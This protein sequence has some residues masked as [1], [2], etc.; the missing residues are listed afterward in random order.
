M[1]MGLGELPG[2]LFSLDLLIA[3]TE[4]EPGFIT[5]DNPAHWFDPEAWS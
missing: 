4:D 1:G 2:R 5:S 3:H